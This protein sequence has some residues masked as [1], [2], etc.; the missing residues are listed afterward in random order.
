MLRDVQLSRV[1]VA[2]AGRWP[3]SE[4]AI[5]RRIDLRRY[6]RWLVDDVRRVART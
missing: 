5:D 2:V 3:T 6:D 4:T 1:P